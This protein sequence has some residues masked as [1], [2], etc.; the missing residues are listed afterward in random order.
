MGID[1]EKIDEG[2]LR[3]NVESYFRKTQIFLKRFSI[4]WIFVFNI[5]FRKT[6]K[7]A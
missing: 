6:I 3:K 1:E 7:I 2:T 4:L 5:N